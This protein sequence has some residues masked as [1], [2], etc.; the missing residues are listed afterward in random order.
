MFLEVFATFILN[1]GRDTG[2]KTIDIINQ[3][4]NL[5][6][7]KEFK[8]H[9]YPLTLLMDVWENIN[10]EIDLIVNAFSG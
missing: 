4:F 9:K 7:H 5:G 6:V 1:T 3:V 10:Q 8:K 2:F